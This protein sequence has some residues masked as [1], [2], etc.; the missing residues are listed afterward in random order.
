MICNGPKRRCSIAQPLR[1]D[2]FKPH[3]ARMIEHGRATGL[4][5]LVERQARSGAR[6]GPRQPHAP[7]VAPDDQPVTIVLDF[8]DRGPAGGLEARIGMH[9]SMN[10]ARGTRRWIIGA[11]SFA[12]ITQS[13]LSR[14]LLS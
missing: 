1:H 7:A 13:D 4:D 14:R 6:E 10:P 3:A 11:E 8:V 2:A 12:H 9:G 5:M